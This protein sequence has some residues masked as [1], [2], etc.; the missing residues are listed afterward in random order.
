MRVNLKVLCILL[1]CIILADTSKASENLTFVWDQ[2]FT[3]LCIY[4]VVAT[5]WLGAMKV[6]QSVEQMA[7]LFENWEMAEEK[8]TVGRS[9]FAQ[10]YCIPT[11]VYVKENRSP[12]RRSREPSHVPLNYLS[13]ILNKSRKSRRLIQEYISKNVPKSSKVHDYTRAY[14]L[15]NANAFRERACKQH[16]NNKKPQM[17][18][19]REN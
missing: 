11:N 13:R 2:N 9:R 10:F 12:P 3:L 8:V 16:G 1:L 17:E 15:H 6:K 7:L 19:E 14:V 4:V 5:F 18:M